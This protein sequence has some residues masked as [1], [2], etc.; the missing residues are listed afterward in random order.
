MFG[1]R[2]R[3]LAAGFRAAAVRGRRIVAA[4][5][6]VGALGLVA[7]ATWVV[8][9][10]APAIAPGAGPGV[11][12]PIAFS[13][14]KHLSLPSG[15]L[16]CDSC[17]QMVFSGAA[18]GRPPTSRCLSCHGGGDGDGASADERRLIDYGRAGEEV[19]WQRIWGLPAFVFFPHHR[20][21][22]DAGIACVTCHGDFPSLDQP[23][24]RPLKTLAMEDCIACHETSSPTRVATQ[25]STLS[26][27]PAV[28]T[29]CNT[30][31]R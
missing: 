16:S 30:C 1:F 8:P 26:A 3:Q 25:V 4:P 22:E 23:P 15:R 17:H 27:Q 21:T 18:A 6:L 19:P 28:S 10:V 31:H 12:Q 20:H 14:K 5:A 13:H 24:S 11:V 7:A 9:G 2:F 29:D